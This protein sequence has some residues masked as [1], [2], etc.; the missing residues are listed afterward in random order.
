MFKSKSRDAMS[1][2]HLV[3]EGAVFT[4]QLSGSSADKIYWCKQIYCCIKLTLVIDFKKESEVI[5]AGHSLHRFQH[6]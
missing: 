3:K 4:E 5:N 1:M 6:L 2:E